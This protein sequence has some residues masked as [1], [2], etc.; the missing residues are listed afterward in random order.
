[1]IHRIRPFALGFALMSGLTLPAS[2][3]QR[4]STA[5]FEGRVLAQTLA[6]PAPDPPP[7]GMFAD[8]LVR[9]ASR[10]HA[11]AIVEAAAQRAAARAAA[12][13]AA[14]RAAAQPAAHA[15]AA[16]PATSA[17]PAAVPPAPAGG[18]RGI[19]RNAFQSLGSGAVTW[20]ERVAM[21]ESGDNPN[22]QSP[23]GYMGLFQFARSTWNG[24][25]YAS[26]SPFDAVAN[27]S[28]AAWLYSRDGP[29]QW[30]CK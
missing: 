16:L 8:E 11:L 17:P 7:S 3:T 4:V 13:R 6:A 10:R 9:A 21:C 23:S 29:S 25:P 24:T 14:A 30:G 12:Q 20:A 15:V 19:I 1:M 28:A 26:R 22:A 2:H 27:A 18:V 5:G